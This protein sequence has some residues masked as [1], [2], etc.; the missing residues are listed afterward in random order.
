[1]PLK[2][3]HERVEVT[4][5]SHSTTFDCKGEGDDCSHHNNMFDNSRILITTKAAPTALEYASHVT[6]FYT[7]HSVD[8]SMGYDLHHKALRSETSLNTGLQQYSRSYVQ[9]K[10]CPIKRYD[11]TT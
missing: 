2:L 11:I 7:H 4:A 8:T 6:Q 5:A 9:L 10:R 1:M 3:S